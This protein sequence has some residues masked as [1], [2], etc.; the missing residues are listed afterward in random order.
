MLGKHEHGHGTLN[1]AIEGN[2]IVI[3]LHAPG[4]D[5]VGFEHPASTAEDKAT[6]ANALATL[7]APL[8]LFFLPN[9]AVCR[10]DRATVAQVAGSEREHEKES[11]E[12]HENHEEHKEH[13]GH[14]EFH[15]EYTL[16]C[17]QPQAIRRIAFPFFSQ[18]PRSHELDVT[19]L[20]AGGQ[21]AYEVK[22]D[23]PAIEIRPGH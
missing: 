6:L 11:H 8:S 14:S 23:T 21:T 18:F 10:V 4:D 5:I 3:E 20:T 9:Q 1:I 15:A 19:L 7:K 16:T 22:R 13:E 17:A 2:K 12:K